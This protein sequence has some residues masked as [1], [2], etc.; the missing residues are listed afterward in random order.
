MF[1]DTFSKENSGKFPS[2][3]THMSADGKTSTTAIEPVK[4][5]SD[6]QSNFFDL[7]LTDNPSVELNDVPGDMV[8]T[9]GSGL[10]PHITLANAMFQLDR[11]AGAWAKDT[12]ADVAK[13]RG[14]IEQLLKDKSSAPLGGAWGDPIVNVLEVNLALTSKYGPP[15]Q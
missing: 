2:S 9:S 12:K 11:V 14:E 1:F 7:W 8:T 13:V 6:I 10:D 5:G 15:P 4:E 3:V